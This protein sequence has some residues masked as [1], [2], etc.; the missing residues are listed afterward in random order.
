VRL[1][2][3]LRGYDSQGV[4]FEEET[5]SENLCRNG[6]AFMTRYDIKI[7]TD[8]EI[9]IPFSNHTPARITRA[10]YARFP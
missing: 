1:P 2:L 7:G 4:P 5:S 9:Y 8:V 10:E 3:K 6:A